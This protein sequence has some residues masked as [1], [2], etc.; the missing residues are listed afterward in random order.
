MYFTLTF[1]INLQLFFVSRL[2]WSRSVRIAGSPTLSQTIQAMIVPFCECFRVSCDAPVF[3]MNRNKACVLGAPLRGTHSR[4][5]LLAWIWSMNKKAS[6]DKETL[7]LFLFRFFTIFFSL[8]SCGFK[9]RTD[10]CCFLKHTCLLSPLI[11]VFCARTITTYTIFFLNL[12]DY[13]S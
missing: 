13:F 2:F 3:V 12:F 10:F 4:F 11:D 1:T 5:V 7:S 8:G 6:V 9:S